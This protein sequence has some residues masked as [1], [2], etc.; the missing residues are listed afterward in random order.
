MQTVYLEEGVV[1]QNVSP[2]S[3]SINFRPPNPTIKI[4]TE[5]GLNVPDVI[6][7][8]ALE[9]DPTKTKTIQFNA[10]GLAEVK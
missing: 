6:I 1:M 9:S 5:T 4:K 3:L 10:A 7:T 8:L 2:S